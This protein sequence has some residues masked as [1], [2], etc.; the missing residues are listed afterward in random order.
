MDRKSPPSYPPRP[1]LP[2]TPTS[3]RRGPT[4]SPHTPVSSLSHLQLSNAPIKSNPFNLHDQVEDDPRKSPSIGSGRKGKARLTQSARPVKSVFAA[5]VKG[6]TQ[7][8]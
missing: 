4:H 7:S 1:P 2:S 8:G 5:A 3:S 6:I